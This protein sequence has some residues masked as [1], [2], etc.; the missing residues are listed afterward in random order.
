[1]VAWLSLTVLDFSEL[2]LEFG[3]SLTTTWEEEKEEEEE[4]EES[5]ENEDL[6]G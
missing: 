6:T 4:E 3:P 1:M 2:D 5:L